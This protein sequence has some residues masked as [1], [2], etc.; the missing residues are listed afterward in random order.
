MWAHN[1]NLP[2]VF[3]SW[4][5][6]VDYCETLTHGG[7]SDWRLPNRRELLSLISDGAF[8]PPLPADHPFNN[9][10][11]NSYW[12]GTSFANDSTSAWIVNLYNGISDNKTKTSPYYV[13]PVRGG[14]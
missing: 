14:Q 7:Y 4:I 5:N 13:W 10:V 11:G 6:A 2:V 3:K 1:A 12:T 8:N 9:V